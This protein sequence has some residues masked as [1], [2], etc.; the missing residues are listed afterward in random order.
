MHGWMGLRQAAA[1]LSHF[2]GARVRRPALLQELS[3]SLMDPK[4]EK[5]FGQNLDDFLFAMDHLEAEEKPRGEMAEWIRNPGV[6]PLDCRHHVER[7][8][9]LDAMV[10]AYEAL[11]RSLAGGSRVP[12]RHS[13]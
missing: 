8:F 13:A 7:H 11:Y 2:T 3:A 10:D 1:A 4:L 6:D 5:Q 9:S 12:H